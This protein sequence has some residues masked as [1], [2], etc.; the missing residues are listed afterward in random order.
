MRIMYE[1]GIPQAIE[2]AATKAGESQSQYIKKSIVMRLR[3]EGFLSGDIVTNKTEQRHKEKIQRLKEYIA[4][5][6]KK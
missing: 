5:E 1:T 4:A 3:N 6:E 2:Q